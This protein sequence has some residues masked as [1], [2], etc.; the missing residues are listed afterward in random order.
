[1]GKS[2]AEVGVGLK[3]EFCRCRLG[4]ELGLNFWL[5]LWLKV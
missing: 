5:P 2:R 3:V 1:M 4:G